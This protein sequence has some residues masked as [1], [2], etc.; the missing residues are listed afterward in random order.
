MRFPEIIFV[1]NT[2]WAP[3]EFRIRRPMVRFRLLKTSL[4]GVV[5]CV[6]AGPSKKESHTSGVRRLY[7]FISTLC[8]LT[9]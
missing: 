2:A 9:K 4:L 7:S 1:V 5:K 8:A 3:T 6:G